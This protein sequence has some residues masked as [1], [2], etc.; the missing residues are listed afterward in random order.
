VLDCG[1]ASFPEADCNSG[2]LSTASVVAHEPPSLH[3][4]PE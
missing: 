3:C 1:E 4:G 2:R